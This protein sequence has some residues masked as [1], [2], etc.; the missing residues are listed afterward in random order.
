MQMRKIVLF[1]LVF[2]LILSIP[3]MALAKP[4]ESPSGSSPSPSTSGSDEVF[5]VLKMESTGDN[6]TMLQLRLR[7]LGYF[8]YIP[9]GSY[10]GLTRDGVIKFQE[11]NDLDVDGTVGEETFNKLFGKIINR[12]KLADTV[13]VVSGPADNKKTKTYGQA[14]DW[15][16]VSAAFPVGATA[17]ITDF[18]S[19]TTFSVKRTGGKS[20]AEIE[21]TAKA[22]YT[23]FLKTFG[24]AATWEK[25]AVVVT[26]GVTNYAASL[27]GWPH[28]NDSV[29][30]NGMEGHTCL[31]FSGCTSEV[32]GLS[33]SEHKD[34][35]AKATKKE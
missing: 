32:L 11:Q 6:V 8:S 2:I 5:S 25:R 19:G 29:S 35:I 21:T 4:S 9:T 33:D 3:A 15:Q 20:H 23:N 26:I 16:T 14:A 28:G 13:K 22:D 10:K 1:S 17:T 34:M 27:F 18:N 30:S 31:Y 7:D 12:S 24:G